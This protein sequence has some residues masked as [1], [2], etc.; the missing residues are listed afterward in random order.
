PSRPRT[1]TRCTCR[2]CRSSSMPRTPIP[3]MAFSP[4][5]RARRCAWRTRHSIPPRASPATPAREER[6]AMKRERLKPERP[7]SLGQVLVLFV[8]FLFV[9]LA[10]SA[11]GV[12]YANWLLTDRRLQNVSD[13]AALAGASQFDL[14]LNRSCGGP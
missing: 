9:L 1:S 11:L 6:A 12:D 5:P 10:V 13:H 7:S 14:R 8:L 3:A 4:S 2:C